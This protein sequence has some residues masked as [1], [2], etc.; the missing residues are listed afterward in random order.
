MTQPKACTIALCVRHAVT[1]CLIARGMVS[2]YLIQAVIN[3]APRSE[4]E[5]QSEE[6]RQ[7]SLCWKLLTEAAYK[8]L[9]EWAYKD[10]EAA[11][12]YWLEEFP[13]YPPSEQRALIA[14]INSTDDFYSA[15]KSEADHP[16]AER[17][18]SP[19]HIENPQVL[20]FPLP[21]ERLPL[22]E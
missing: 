19:V 6:W 16:N 9:H 11:S 20:P 1:L 5:R 10:F 13:Y 8:Y 7:N 2:P 18:L 12:A 22:F 15:G 17:I 4:S 21:N 14:H 3:S